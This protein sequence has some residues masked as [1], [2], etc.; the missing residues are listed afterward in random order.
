MFKL[1]IRSEI[2]NRSAEID[3]FV[4]EALNEN[5]TI[6][7]MDE[8]TNKLLGCCINA[9]AHKTNYNEISLEEFTE[10]YKVNR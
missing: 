8:N 1:L 4:Y 6:L 9:L 5:L 7:A 2:N 10:S 3:D